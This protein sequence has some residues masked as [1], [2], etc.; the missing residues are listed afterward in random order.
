M[1]PHSMIREALFNIDPEEIAVFQDMELEA[2]EA[3]LAA[4]KSKNLIDE[5]NHL[6]N[7]H[8]R[9]HT[10]SAER[11]QKH[12]NSKKHDVTPGNHEETR[13]NGA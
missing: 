4:L 12:R 5:N 7:W 11:V 9:Q 6:T 1:P 13:C 3:I 8:K 2:V 10:T